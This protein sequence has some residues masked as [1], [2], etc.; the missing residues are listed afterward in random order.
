MEEIK[1]M[2]ANTQPTEHKMGAMPI[3]KLLITMSLPMI[4]SMLVQALYNIVD[5]IFVARI[6]EAALTAVSM[7]FPIQNLMI[8]VCSGTCVGVNALLS[9]SLGEQKP[10][11]AQSAATNGLFLAVLGAI[12]F[13]LFGIFGTRA[14]FASQ[15]N[16][17]LIIEYGVQYLQICTIFSF[18][19]FLEITLERILQSTGRTIYNMY[20]QGIGAITNIIL[21]PIMIFGLF[22]FPALGI[23]GA[24]IA[25]VLGQ[26]FAMF[27]SLLFNLK[28]NSDISIK[29]RGFRP[30]GQTIRIIY[31]VGIPSVIMIS[32]SSAMTYGLN[33][34]LG[35]LDTVAVTILGVYFKLQSFVFMPVF[36]LNNGMIPIIAYNYG[37]KNKKRIMDTIK[38][39]I[40]IAIGIMLAG[41]V[42]FQT[43]SVQ[44]LQLFNAS[45]NMLKEGVPA[46]KQISL[47]FIFAGYCIIVSSVFQALGNGVYSLVVS[48]ARQLLCILPAA[49]FL[50]NTFGL[51]AAW[52]AFPL[53]EIV[54]LT[55]CTILFKRIYDQKIK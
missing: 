33:L 34:I 15:T 12:A 1:I 30:H 11:D 36:G 5:S 4:I 43:F 31:A 38:L 55:L 29:M 16:D 24:A 53:A 44:L 47:S 8:A 18:G 40:I 45:D 26:I 28:Y 39:S 37:A 50:A 6:D 21:D 22:G 2:S 51:H 23:R 19:L 17:P 49:Y 9:R 7:A 27:L 10:K 52:Y 20:S 32:I 46:L 13:A 42:L 35:A 41:L 3:P 14:F 54:S 48:I 25:T